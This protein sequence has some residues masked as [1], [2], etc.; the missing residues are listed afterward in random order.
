[1]ADSYWI[2]GGP[3]PGIT[4]E[5][6][7][8]SRYWTRGAPEAFLGAQDVVLAPTVGVLALGSQAQ[9]D[10]PRIFNPGTGELATAGQYFVYEF[11]GVTADL[12]L[13][14]EQPLVRLVAGFLPTTGVLTLGLQASENAIP[15][16]F[17]PSTGSMLTLGGRPFEPTFWVDIADFV[18]IEIT[19]ENY[20]DF[21]GR[22]LLDAWTREDGVRVMVRMYNRTHDVSV[23]VSDWVVGS[24]PTDVSFSVKLITGACRYKLQITSDSLDTDLFAHGQGLLPAEQV[25]V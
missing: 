3:I 19:G 2:K 17:Y 5:P 12:S 7:D 1:M 22:V 13:Q 8:T 11:V 24:T 6:Q 21:A 10:V 4:V 25:S 15:E 20:I 14:G 16:Y 23:G 9:P 18:D